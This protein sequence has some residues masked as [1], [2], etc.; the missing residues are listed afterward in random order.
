MAL[1]TGLTRFRS[2]V[3]YVKAETTAG[4]LSALP[5]AGDAFLLTETP[6]LSQI[7]NYANTQEIGSMLFSREKVLNYMDFAT[8]DLPFYA[9]PKTAGTAPEEDL[10]LNHFFG[11]GAAVS[12]TYVYNFANT[13]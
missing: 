4:T 2:A 6:V 11:A 5:V 13:R 12:S 8:F 10:L 7:G 1:P 9:K 3:V